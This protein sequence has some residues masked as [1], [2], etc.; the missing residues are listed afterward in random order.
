MGR[1]LL[2]PG[3]ILGGLVLLAPQGIHAL[4]LAAILAAGLTLGCLLLTLLQHMV[5]AKWG[6]LLLGRFEA[7]AGPWS[8]ATVALALLP[9]L[10]RPE[11]AYDWARGGHPDQAWWLSP[12]FFLGRSVFYLAFWA[13]LGLV[14]RRA[15]LRGAYATNLAAPGFFFTCLTGTFASFDWAMSLEPPYA[16]TVYGMLFLTIGV[17][18]A[19]GVCVAHLCATTDDPRFDE[20]LRRDFGNL[21]FTFL[22]VWGYLTFMQ[23]IISWSGNI[24]TESDYFLRRAEGL[25]LWLG[26]GLVGV[27]FFGPFFLLLT[28]RVRNSRRGLGFTAAFAAVVWAGFVVWLVGPALAAPWWLDLAAVAGVGMLWSAAF[29]A[30]VAAPVPKGAL[31]RA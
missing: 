17:L 28:P 30:Q 22:M 10:L 31:L 2:V 11:A 15:S 25:W 6:V 12:G 9:A 19:M 20:P 16:S 24:K 3:L 14:L 8:L 27:G 29:A 21:L 1:W 23:Y 5:H 7:G 13:V 26:D 4:T 18:G